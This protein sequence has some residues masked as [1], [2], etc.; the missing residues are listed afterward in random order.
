MDSLNPETMKWYLNETNSVLSYYCSVSVQDYLN[1]LAKLN[2]IRMKEIG[3]QLSIHILSPYTYYFHV[4]E[5]MLHSCRLGSD[6]PL[7]DLIP[8]SQGGDTSHAPSPP[9]IFHPDFLPTA[10][11]LH[12]CHQLFKA[13]K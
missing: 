7:K 10:P 4:S 12:I 6:T 3:R 2:K 8:L 1:V 5:L 9:H 13:T 11:L